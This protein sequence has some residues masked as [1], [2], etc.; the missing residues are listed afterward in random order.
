MPHVVLRGGGGK[1]H[2]NLGL[3]IQPFGICGRNVIAIR[4]KN[5]KVRVVACYKAY[6]RPTALLQPYR[7]PSPHHEIVTPYTKMINHTTP[8]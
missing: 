7:L 5:I 6:I 2:L 1:A 3:L 4:I 8:P